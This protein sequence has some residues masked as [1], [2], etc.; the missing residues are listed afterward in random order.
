MKHLSFAL[1]LLALVAAPAL[2]QKTD[3]AR[4]SE[5]TKV[6]ASDEFGGRS[7]GTEGEKKTIAWA[8]ERFKAL[9]LQPGGPDGQWT[10]AVPLIHTRL[11]DG[12]VT[13]GATP[14]RQGTDVSMTTVRAAPQ[15]AIADAPLVFVG[16]GVSAPEAKWD[17]FKGLD[18]EGKVAVFLVNDPDFEA[19]AGDDAKGRFGDRRMTYYGR[20]TYKY[21][22]AARRGAIGALIVHDTDGAGYPW[23]TANASN[24]ENYDIVRDASDPRIALQGWLSGEAATRLF[25]AEGLDLAALRIKARSAAFAPVALKARFSAKLPVTV[26]R[27]ESA[28]VLAKIPGRTKPDETVQ[29]AAHW[30]AYGEG[31]PD[32]QGKTIRPGANDDA[33]G[34]AGV[35]ELARLFKAAP[36]PD[37]TLVFALWT[38]EERGLL[39]SEWY[40]THPVDPLEKTAANLTLDIL[41]T[42]GEA[43]DVIL[44]GA[45]QSSLEDLLGDAVRAQSR[46]ITPET[47]SERGLFYR[48]DHFSVV[49]RGV[50]S[51]Q[52]MALGGASDMRT[53]GREAGQKWLDA[54]M[55][56]YHKTCDA[57]DARWNFTGVAQDVDLFHSMGQRLAKSGVWPTWRPASEF[58][59]IRAKSAAARN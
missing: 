56:C 59:A 31:P 6:L 36:Q 9:G 37:R 11:G 57:W 21:E 55:A 23:S 52:L 48:A 5:M 49:R 26:E 27:I 30:D 34:V 35:L 15:V 18:L 29:F 8:I 28:N 24:G 44:V 4:L 53:G 40:A 12:P 22:E 54:Y 32:A 17:D 42:A 3:P 38:A 47:A 33:L 14:L 46:A 43:K 45:G 20:W 50:P 1:P 39:G 51:L 10:Q 25:A 2:A 19:A 13:F 16:Y 41:Q 58:L 7:P